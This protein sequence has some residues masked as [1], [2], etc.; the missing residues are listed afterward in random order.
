MSAN[1]IKQEKTIRIVNTG[2]DESNFID[3]IIVF[4]GKPKITNGEALQTIR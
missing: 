1:T 3:N 4:L 2:K